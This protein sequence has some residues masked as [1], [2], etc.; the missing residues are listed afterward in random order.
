MQQPTDTAASALSAN[1][2]VLTVNQIKGVY[3]S[4]VILDH[5]KKVNEIH[6]VAST[7]RKP[8]QIVR[9]VETMLFVK[10]RIKID[11]RTISMVQIPDEQLLRIPIARPEIREVAEEIVGDQKRFRVTIQGASRTVVGQAHEKI[12]HPTPFHTVARATINAIEKLLSHGIDVRLDLFKDVLG[13][14][15]RFNFVQNYGG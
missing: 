5:A 9:D 15:T 12:T 1:D 6:I 13:L 3:A 8:K 7:E 14:Y 10:H 11:Y 4:C 2:L